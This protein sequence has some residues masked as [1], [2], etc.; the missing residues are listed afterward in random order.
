MLYLL[1]GDGERGGEL[2][3]AAADTDQA[4][5]VFKL[6]ARMVAN[7]PEPQLDLYVFAR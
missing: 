2:V 6:A 4:A 1:L 3:S 5:L 7:D